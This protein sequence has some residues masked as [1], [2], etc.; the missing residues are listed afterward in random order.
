MNLEYRSYKVVSDL[1]TACLITSHEQVQLIQLI[2][3]LVG[4]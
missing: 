4:R 2:S 1:Y 3:N